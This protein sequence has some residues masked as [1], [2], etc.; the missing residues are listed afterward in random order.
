MELR[1]Y[2]RRQTK[3][4]LINKYSI[5]RHMYYEKKLNPGKGMRRDVGWPA[6]VV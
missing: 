5:C 1:V 6:V 3:T 2:W 4:N